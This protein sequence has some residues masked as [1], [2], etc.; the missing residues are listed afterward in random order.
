MLNRFANFF[1]CLLICCSF[2]GYAEIRELKGMDQVA[3]AVKDGDFVLFNVTEVLI[4]SPY[5]LGSQAWRKYVRE[6]APLW[7][8]Q[9]GFNIHDD[10]TLYVAKQIPQQ[11]VESTTPS[12]IDA[13]QKRGVTVSALTGRGLNEWYTTQAK[14]IDVLTHR[15]LQALKMDFTRTEPMFNRVALG[16]LL[17]SH[18]RYGIFFN[19]DREH[20]PFLHDVVQGLEKRPSTVVVIDDKRDCLEPIEAAM[21]KLGVPFIGFLYTRATAESRAFNP[22]V[23]NVQLESLIFSDKTLT[24]AEATKIIEEQYVGTDPDQFFYKLLEKIYEK[25]KPIGY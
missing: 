7:P 11:N 17:D 6:K 10:L 22:M 13:L 19:N 15:Q 1:V 16:A 21:K 8:K 18:Y 23:A 14:G 12:L 5:Q 4:T 2:E 3:P 20:G 25:Q 9:P 24:D